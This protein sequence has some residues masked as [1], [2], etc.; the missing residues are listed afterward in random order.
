VNLL[1]G[2]TIPAAKAAQTH[3]IQGHLLDEANV[4]RAKNGTRQCRACRA[5]KNRAWAKKNR[6][7]RRQLDRQSYAR[8]TA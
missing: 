2:A 6:A 8:R 1:R 3:C 5:I 4:Y 7:R